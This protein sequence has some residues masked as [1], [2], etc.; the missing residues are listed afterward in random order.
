M[1]HTFSHMHTRMHA[2]THTRKHT[3]THTHTSA[4]FSS[5]FFTFL[6][7]HPCHP[8]LCLCLFFL[9]LSLRHTCFQ[10]ASWAAMV[11]RQSPLRKS[12]HLERSALPAPHQKKKP[13]AWQC[14]KEKQ[15][16]SEVEKMEDARR[17]SLCPILFHIERGW[18]ERFEAFQYLSIFFF[19]PKLQFISSV[20]ALPSLLLHRAFILHHTTSVKAQLVPTLTLSVGDLSNVQPT[21]RQLPWH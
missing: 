18:Y 21:R 16:S 15:H 10:T 14:W 8:S 6:T 19:H 9:F 2:R 11:L 20:A 4:I 12:L 13:L 17:P 7:I 1:R 3:N 5:L